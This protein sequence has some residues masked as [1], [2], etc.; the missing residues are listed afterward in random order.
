MKQFKETKALQIYSTLHIPFRNY[1]KQEKKL[2]TENK[3]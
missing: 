1:I 3:V 2:L